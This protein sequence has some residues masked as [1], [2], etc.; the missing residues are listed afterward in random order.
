MQ[1]GQISD[2]NAE[3]VYLYYRFAFYQV[4]ELLKLGEGDSCG[5]AKCRKANKI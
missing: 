4:R 5:K 2:F 3:I 1:S